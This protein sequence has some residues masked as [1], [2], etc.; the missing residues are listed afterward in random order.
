MEFEDR[1]AALASKVRDQKDAIQTEEATKNAF[2]MPFIATILGYDV[3]NPLEVVPEFNADVGTK[4]NEK[5]DYAILRERDVQLLIECKRSSGALTIEHASQLFRYF[6]VTNARI[7]VLTNGQV[8]NFYTDLDVPN[9]MDDRPFLVLDLLDIDPTLIPEL[10]KLSKDVFD[11]DSVINAAEELKYVGSLKRAISAE[12]KSPSEQFVRLLT[13]QVYDGRF[14]QEVRGQF[15]AL[16]S[17]ALRQFTSEQV[18]DRLKTA[19]GASY[20]APTP[21]ATDVPEAT[22]ES[23]PVVEEDLTRDPD[24]ETTLEEL[25]GFQIVKAIACAEVKPQRVVHRDA[26]SY[27][28]VLLDDNNRKPIARL[29]FNSKKQKYLGLLDAD[30]N[31]TRVPIDS[32]EDIYLHI[33]TIRATVRRYLNS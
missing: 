32:L 3:F 17:K 12:F 26:K 11:I 20:T 4:R 27:F 14:T 22:V 6:S 2:V 25:E 9:R 29:W 16:V 28:A 19:L 7:A 31:E 33:D 30:K 23:A 13:S 5:V 24:I 15:T 21:S 8:Y 1:L 18:N 10:K